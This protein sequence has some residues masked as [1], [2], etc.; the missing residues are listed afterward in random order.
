MLLIPMIYPKYYDEIL[1]HLQDNKFAFAIENGEI[2]RTDSFCKTNGYQCESCKMDTV[3]LGK[4]CCMQYIHAVLEFLLA[5]K[6]HPEL[7][8]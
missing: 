5:N 7:F 4:K 6:L 2:I 8:L 1:Y 3:D